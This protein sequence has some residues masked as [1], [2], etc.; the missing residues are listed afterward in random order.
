MGK[1]IFIICLVVFFIVCIAI[2]MFING[3]QE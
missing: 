1:L 3:G 2:D